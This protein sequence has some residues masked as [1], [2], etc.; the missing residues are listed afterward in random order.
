MRIECLERDFH[1]RFHAGANRIDARSARV[2]A[3]GASGDVE[4]GMTAHQR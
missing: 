3:K 2:G 1:N 4:E